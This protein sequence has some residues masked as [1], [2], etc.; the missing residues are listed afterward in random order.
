M[1][2]SRRAVLGATA[3]TALLAACGRSANNGDLNGILDRLVT[4][5]L[6]E[7]P[8]FATS[9]AVSEEQAGGRYI[10]RLSD[11]SKEGAL[12]LRGI[13][14]RALADLRRLNRDSLE[15]QDGVTYDVVT[16]ALTDQIASAQFEHGGG[17][18]APYVVT[19]LTG[20]YTGIPDFMASQHPVTNRE[21][22]DAYL[23]R[24]SAY[25]RVLDQESARIAED[26]AAGIIPPSFCLSRLDSEGK[27]VGAIGLL[28]TFAAIPTGQ[29]VL[30]TALA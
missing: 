6:R 17:A 24:L 14:E 19:Q 15:G 9:L 4:D 12:R 29:N 16:T 25:A 23:S 3:A 26:A 11:S 5:V 30:V 18:Q 21:Q 1:H 28:R 13:A 2:M 10:D 7:A 8:E 22:A 27:E 20:A